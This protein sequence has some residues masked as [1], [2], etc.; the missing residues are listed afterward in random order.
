[1]ISRIKSVVAVTGLVLGVVLVPT[2]S[3]QAVQIPQST[4]VS[5][6]PADFTPN[7]SCSTCPAPPAALDGRVEAIVQTGNTVIMGGR[8]DQARE[9]G[10]SVV[11]SR[12]NI[13]AFDAT[14][15]VISTAF[16]PMVDGEVTSLVLS[17]DGTSV[18]VGGNF[19]KIDGK[20]PKNLALL[21]VAT[22]ARVPGF[23]PPAFSGGPINDMKLSNGRL[24]VGGS[25]ATIGV[26]AQPA[27]ATV[28][29]TTGALDPFM[30]VQLSG[31]HNGGKT[32]IIK[33]DITADGS[34]LVGIGNFVNVN[35]VRH[36]QAMMLDLTGGS[37]AVANWQTAFYQGTCSTR[38]DS[39][40]R[41]LDFSPDGS[42]FVIS[43]TGAYGGSTSPCD[44]TSRW[45][46]GA[47]GSN[48]TAT[49]TD[50]TGGDTTYGVAITGTTVY[51]GGHF[52]WQNNAFAGDHA[53]Q[54]AID[55]QGL[56]ALDPANG[57]P[58]AW[59]PTRD[60][61]VGVF[62]MLATPTGL[63][64]GSDTD[65]VGNEFH[66]KIA[67]FPLAGG[68]V[69]PANKTGQLPGNVYLAGK[70]SGT[71]VDVLSTRSFDGTTAGSL[72]AQNAGGIAWGS[73]R[74]AFMVNG[75]LYTGDTSG[76]FSA[77]T[78][79]GSTFGP[80]VAVN[81]SDLLVA[82]TAWHTDVAKLTGMFFAGG[83]LYY[84]I[85]GTTNLFYRFFTPSSGVVGAVRYTAA[86]NSTGVD[87]SKVNGMF[88][89]GGTL[90]LA[91]S[92]TGGL[93]SM[94]FA[95]GLPVAGTV[96]SLSTPGVD[97]RARGLFLRPSPNVP[98][99]A[100]FTSS[101]TNGVCTF[102][103]SASGDSDGFIASYAWDFGDGAADTGVKP[104]HTYASSGSRTVTL[105]VTD[106]TGA[107]VAV[108]HPVS[109]QL[110][111]V[112]PTSS[113][114]VSCLQLTCAYDGTGS[115]DPDGTIASYAWSFSDGTTDS[116]AKVNHT[117][118]HAGTYTATLL[119]TD[120]RSGTGTSSTTSTV[121]TASSAIAFRAEAGSNA[122]VSTASVTV[123]GAVQ[124]GDALL[125]YASVANATTVPDPS[126]P[127][128][129]GW[130]KVGGPVTTG[131]MA[132][133]VWQRV[134]AAGD[135]GQPVTI[136]L[137]A[138]SKV[139]LELVAYSGTDPTN[140]VA[141]VAS[142]ADTALVTA[143]PAP[144]ANVT[145][146]GSWVVDYWADKSSTT[147]TWTAP[148]GQQVRD[149]SIGA[150]S[151]RVTSL[152]TDSGGAVGTG[153]YG[154]STA[155]TD[156]TSKGTEVT[157]VLSPVASANANPTA[158]FTVG[159]TGLVCQLN[160]TGS[161]D[162][163][164]FVTGWA[165]DFGDG[166]TGTGATTSHTYAQSGSYPVQLVVTDDRGGT[167]S[168]SHA[169]AVT[170][171]PTAIA[172]RAK[173]STTTNAGNVTVTV[174]STVQPGDGLLLFA[175]T[176]TTVTIGDPTGVTGWT[177]VPAQPVTTAT[178]VTQVWQKV[179]AAG[180]AG[181]QL[182][183]TL[184]ATAKVNLEL[185]A[186]S[187]TSAAGPVASFASGSEPATV[188]SHVSPTATATGAGQWVLT[189]WADKSSTTTVWTP[190]AG[191]DVVDT[192]YG[193]GAGRVTTLVV[194]SGGPAGVGPYGGLT[195]MT[196]AVS[197]ATSFT[198]VLA[199]GEA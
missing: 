40:M 165:W 37:A 78:Y 197:R 172:F 76:T 81:T 17:P 1:V 57:L 72:V 126:A 117:Y 104:T 106:D 60:R 131:A 160:G 192:L 4:V 87:W 21:S 146:G 142:N 152:L 84:T 97:W 133:Q 122:Q 24:W 121:A 14:T 108:S 5:D 184:G 25:F 53:S 12:G 153:G 182:K 22:G 82:L 116:G 138:L 115:S 171:I 137:G 198:I 80:A 93:S 129:T 164:G 67:F 45:E 140:P 2:L 177:A 33:F 32:S 16:A 169:A 167:G 196:D 30:G 29:P 181:K 6:N 127:G 70:V 179:A 23:T 166:S 71:G 128:L 124:Q 74:G 68:T 148:A 47:T 193:A 48:L 73:V 180:D 55:R 98:P 18:Y 15:G 90:Y 125:L 103:A 162:S 186:Y 143:H 51:V 188:T 139:G 144:A 20:G 147:T 7:V 79:D 194:D 34:R 56:A 176:A 134:A 62:D 157:V 39:Y 94:A 199:Q 89:S 100:A 170:G 50:Y 159:C 161:S 9:A 13:L 63:W 120:D 92:S 155:S 149:T 114:T 195:A 101:C 59:N 69:V 99:T 65:T 112:N 36:E 145:L 190:P 44:E 95:G 119:V 91:N 150:G 46:T 183:V 110:A 185:V 118:P 123:P 64:V 113:F 52:R 175:T 102:D 49:W 191:T 130:T 41:D 156:A 10:K 105:T 132:T 8:F 189:Y 187:G 31:L 77:R 75:T 19:A 3:A 141:S 66:Q 96:Q 35:G 174:P 88:L 43:T 85:S 11:L 163:D 154:P 136:A 178:A 151:G 107:A 168:A 61:G 26:A 83:R 173:V 38:F 109:V 54:G 86:A 135:A 28:N 42:Y 27:L 158:S 58:F 111:N